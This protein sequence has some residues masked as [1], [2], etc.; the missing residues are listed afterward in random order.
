MASQRP[1]VVLAGWLGCQPRH[2]GQYERMY[3]TLGLDVVTYIATPRM[4][5]AANRSSPPF[6][7]E[8]A[9]PPNSIQALSW[10]I[11][12][13]VQDRNIWFFHAFSNGGCF[14]WEQLR[15]ILSEQ[16]QQQQYSEISES[17]NKG[18]VSEPAGLVFDSSPANYQGTD[19][20]NQALAY[21]TWREKAV[22]RIEAL[23][24]GASMKRKTQERA[25]MYWDGL[26]QDKLDT[27]QLYL[28]CHDD[29]LTRF[30]DVKKLVRYRQDAFGKDRVILKD[31]QSS[32]HCA[33]ILK[34]PDE[35]REAVA[36]FVASCLRDSFVHSR[37]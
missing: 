9:S 1:L 23:W 13:H 32:L 2:L 19:L 5:V 35:Y 25:R 34:H 22:V 27:R 29:D 4:V 24:G 6:L 21:C 37:L 12:R 16:Q 7:S 17:R 36:S 31:W 20:L 11:F 28:C 10:N 15:R 8:D 3:Q 18:A 14:V 33:H 30:E 26:V